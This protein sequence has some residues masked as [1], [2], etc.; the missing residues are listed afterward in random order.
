MVVVRRRLIFWLIKAY[1]RKSKKILI[2]SFFA[3]LAVFF[4][5]LFGAK[6]FKT[7]LVFHRRPVVGLI[8]SYQREN[9]PAIVLT[10][11]SRGLMKVEKD[12]SIKPDLATNYS[13]SD[14]GKTYKFTLTA[15]LKFSDGS[16]FE[17]TDLSYNFSDVSVEKPNKQTVVFKL[18][19]SYAPFLATIS[20][21]VFKKGYIGVGSYFIKN[22]KLNGN[23]VQELTIALVNNRFETIKYL[24]YPTE[25]ALKTAFMLGEVTQ[26]D[27][28]SS[29][30]YRNSSFDKFPRTTAKR[31]INQTRLVTLFYNT[32]DPTLS[33][34]KIRIS[35]NYALPNNFNYGQKASL[36][37]FPE[38]IYFNNEIPDRKQDYD[39]AALLLPKS[40]IDLTIST[41]PRYKK[42]AQEIADSWKKVG[43][44]TEIKEV[45]Q[46]PDRF[47]IFLSDFNLPRDSDQYALWHSGQ[48]SNITKYKNLRID[49]FLEDGRK[50]VNVD[51]RKKIYADF[52]KFLLEDMP[53]SF[54]YF[55]Y[56]YRV[57]RN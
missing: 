28:L 52:Q 32:T 40:K 15:N 13:I 3:G 34:K 55:P 21:P 26:A 5:I 10:K 25:S 4:A 47:Q 48:I 41:F 49:K 8:G 20:K 17:S 53:A 37:Y 24:F 1:I 30:D 9:L 16:K 31:I 38:S 36:P 54:L 11:L 39:H 27:G 56:E 33:D 22:V 23:F 51:D 12:G 35:L 46:V 57:T 19:D 6:Y 18:K 2:F 43:I 45:D 50:T 29:Q 14:K 42:V 7:L 44:K